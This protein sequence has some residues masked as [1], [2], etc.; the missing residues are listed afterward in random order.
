M[1]RSGGIGIGDSK[2][3]SNPSCVKELSEP[4]R[5]G[6]RCPLLSDKEMR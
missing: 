2:T 4:R 1:L 5:G 3:K 6:V